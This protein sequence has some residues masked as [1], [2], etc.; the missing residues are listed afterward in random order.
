MSKRWFVFSSVWPILPAKFHV[1]I[2]IWKIVLTIFYTLS[3]SESI[4]DLGVIMIDPNLKFQSHIQDIVKRA[5]LR[6]SLIVRCFPS[7]NDVNLIRAFKSYVRPL[8][9]Y[10]STVWSPSDIALIDALESV[11]GRFTKRSH[12]C[13]NMSDVDHSSID[14]LSMIW[15]YGLKLYMDWSTLIWMIFHYIQ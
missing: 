8:V 4:T 7:I 13:S 6:S 5:L 9:E 12:G 3:N 11:Q 14:V 2:T 15:W 1:C 10:V